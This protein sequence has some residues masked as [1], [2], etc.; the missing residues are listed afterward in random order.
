MEDK[1]ATMGTEV[2]S[3]ESNVATMLESICIIKYLLMQKGQNT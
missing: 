1:V 3:V 2:D